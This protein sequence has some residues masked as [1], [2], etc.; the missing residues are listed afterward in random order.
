MSAETV[1]SNEP[2]LAAQ[3]GPWSLLIVAA[4]LLVAGPALLLW[5]TR[6][7]AKP[8]VVYADVEECGV[9]DE[10]LAFFSGRIVHPWLPYA[11]PE[12]LTHVGLSAEE[13]RGVSIRGAKGWV[14]LDVLDR[15]AL[16]LEL[17]T[18]A[19]RE[20]RTQGFVNQQLIVRID[21]R[22]RHGTLKRLVEACAD[23][24]VRIW[25]F[26]LLVRSGEQELVRKME[27]FCPTPM[28]DEPGV[29]VL[30]W[31][32]NEHSAERR[33]DLADLEG[34]RLEEV[35]QWLREKSEAT[36][37]RAELCLRPGEAILW[38]EIVTLLH[39]DWAAANVERGTVALDWRDGFFLRY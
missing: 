15:E 27:L 39:A 28:S 31:R 30:E 2:K 6:P 11:E 14:R 35:F 23:P 38:E 3:H 10:D 26:A 20:G 4:C 7:A 18:L 36:G 33:F 8:A 34:A 19:A 17:V 32:R 37:G 12:P 22:T 29:Q 9:R 21:R 16:V 1:A 5:G 25:K 24:R 13:F